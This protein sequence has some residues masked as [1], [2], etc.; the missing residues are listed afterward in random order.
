[1]LTD[2]STIQKIKIIFKNKNISDFQN[3]SMRKKQN[4]LNDST[5]YNVCL[6]LFFEIQVTTV[7]HVMQR[8]KKNIFKQILK[9]FL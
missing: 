2:A 8:R 4:K 9:T 7:M 1:M 3:Y 5:K 6:K